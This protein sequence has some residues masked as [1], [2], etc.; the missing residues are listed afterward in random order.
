LTNDT[1]SFPF[2]PWSTRRVLA[3]GD[4]FED[5]GDLVEDKRRSEDRGTFNNEPKPIVGDTDFTFP[6]SIL[7]DVIVGP[8]AKDEEPE[9]TK[10]TGEVANKSFESLFTVAVTVSD[11]GFAVGGGPKR[12]D[13]VKALTVELP[14]I[15]TTAE[16]H[17]IV[18]ALTSDNGF[19][20]PWTEESVVQG[21]KRLAVDLPCLLTIAEGRESMI[22]AW[23]DDESFTEDGRG[24]IVRGTER[25]SIQLPCISTITVGHSMMVAFCRRPNLKNPSSVSAED[26]P[27]K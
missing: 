14:C 27:G 7:A 18:V 3:G 20:K 1:N 17:P 11:E 16:G 21:A 10:E 22:A 15:I 19:L 25:F 24:F 13:R 12:T 9:K 8:V 2:F 23:T 6:S 26:E 4:S 5:E